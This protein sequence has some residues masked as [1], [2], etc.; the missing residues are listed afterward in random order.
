MVRLVKNIDIEDDQPVLREPRIRKLVKVELL[1][2]SS[3]PYDAMIRNISTFGV[4]ATAP[5][6]LQV[7]QTIKLKK[8]GFGSISGN[9]R[10]VDGREF[11]MQFDQAIDVDLFNFGDR[12]RS[13][14]FIK[15]IDSGHVWRGFDVVKCSKRP[16][17]RTR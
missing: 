13:G 16:G 14:H 1:T 6:K 10:W 12:N 17:F 15:K 11:G 9:V 2:A 4:R 5:V 7:G 8:P 3:G